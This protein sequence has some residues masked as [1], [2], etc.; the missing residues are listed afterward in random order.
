M[1][2]GIDYYVKQLEEKKEFPGKYVEYHEFTSEFDSIYDEVSSKCSEECEEYRNNIFRHE[3]NIFW[4]NFI[5]IGIEVILLAIMMISKYLI[6]NPIFFMTGF[7]DMIAYILFNKL[8]VDYSKTNNI[9]R[10]L[11][12]YK[13]NVISNMIKL[14]NKNLIYE[15]SVDPQIIEVYKKSF[16]NTYC[17]WYDDYIYGKIC[18]DRYIE[19]VNFL[20]SQSFN[21]D[22]ESL[23]FYG[24]FATLKLDKNINNSIKII[25]D[26][27]LIS[28]KRK[29][30]LDSSEFEECF[31]VHADDRI[32]AARI[33]TSDVME[34]LVDIYKKY[35]IGFDINLIDDRLY[36]RVFSEDSFEPTLYKEYEKEKLYYDY[37]CVKLILELAQEMIKVIDSM[38]I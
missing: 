36:L 8:Y 11:S 6:Y 21:L 15:T 13:N 5:L 9:V 31:D 17:Q 28:T 38:E 19:M 16:G 23:F 22:S 1:N 30:N 7:I 32:L 3:E 18:D 29:L 35:N 14:I 37:N 33:L 4:I 34:K 2:K 26:K 10:Y 25:P 20:G 27:A 24:I 12:Y